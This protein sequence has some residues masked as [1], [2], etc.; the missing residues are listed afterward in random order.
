MTKSKGVPAG[1]VMSARFAAV[2]SQVASS[3]R[4]RRRDFF[5]LTWAFIDAVC[6]EREASLW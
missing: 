3:H 6:R 1:A 5:V 4:A 2:P